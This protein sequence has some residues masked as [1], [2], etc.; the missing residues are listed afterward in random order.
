MTDD[1]VIDWEIYEEM[2]PDEQEAERIAEHEY[3][4]Y[5]RASNSTIFPRRS[6]MVVV[7]YLIQISLLVLTLAPTGK[8]I[9]RVG[10]GRMVFWLNSTIVPESCRRS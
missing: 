2:I 9:F 6:V 10:F 4:M 8:V 3:Y 5:I 1:F 7:Y